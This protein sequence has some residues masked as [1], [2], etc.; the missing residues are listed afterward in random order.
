M[1][2]KKMD[3]GIPARSL[4]IS[5]N[6]NRITVTDQITLY[7]LSVLGEPDQG[8]METFSSPSLDPVRTAATTA[9]PVP[10]TRVPQTKKPVIETSLPRPTTLQSPAGIVPVLGAL[11]G[12]TIVLTT[13][14]AITPGTALP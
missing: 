3:T 12:A 7:R 9:T 1:I 8:V 11:A 14:A 6:G 4:A 5:R 13:R 2:S 10:T